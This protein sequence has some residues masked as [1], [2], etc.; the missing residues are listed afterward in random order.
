MIDGAVYKCHAFVFVSLV[1][2]QALALFTE[3]HHALVILFFFG[4]G[5]PCRENY[6][7]VHCALNFAE[8]VY[9]IFVLM[10]AFLSC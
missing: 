5:N 1:Y 8:Y 4:M 10:S 9:S 3:E 2:C 7:F 6:I